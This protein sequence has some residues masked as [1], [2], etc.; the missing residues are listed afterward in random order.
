MQGGANDERVKQVAIAAAIVAA[1]TCAAVALLLGWRFVPGVLGE[2]L[3]TIAGV[4]STPFFL[5]A[6]FVVV[7]VFIVIVLNTVRRQRDGDDFISLEHLEE[8]E[9]QH[10]KELPPRS[11]APTTRD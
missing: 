2:W 5:E 1:V 7:G 6:S 9:R 8:R 4:I 10:T 11:E 3:G